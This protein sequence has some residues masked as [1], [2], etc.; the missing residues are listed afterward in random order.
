MYAKKCKNVIEARG[1]RWQQSIIQSRATLI[2][3]SKF[4]HSS[5]QRFLLHE[6]YI[7]PK[8]QDQYFEHGKKKDEVFN[9]KKRKTQEGIDDQ[10]IKKQNCE[11]L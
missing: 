9:S 2:K 8:N 7:Y 11:R 4:S 1:Y 3:N 10:C 5:Q 6:F